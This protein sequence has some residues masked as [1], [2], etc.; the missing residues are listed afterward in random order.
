MEIGVRKK[1]SSSKGQL[2]LSILSSTT[3]LLLALVSIDATGRPGRSFTITDQRSLDVLWGS[4]EMK[5]CRDCCNGTP[6]ASAQGTLRKDR[7]TRWIIETSFGCATNPAGGGS[8]IVFVWEPSSTNTGYGPGWSYLVQA[9]EHRDGYELNVS[10]SRGLEYR[11][12]RRG[13]PLPSQLVRPAARPRNTGGYQSSDVGTQAVNAC[14]SRSRNH[15]R[16][17]RSNCNGYGGDGR[18]E[19]CYQ[20]CCDI[21][22]KYLNSPQY[23][24]CASSCTRAFLR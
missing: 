4:Y 5:Y 14:R 21:C 19:T 1:M 11:F 17:D 20:C 3:F 2:R 22:G 9:I 12:F 18:G 16:G 24:P 13:V 23:Q 15:L 8:G 7:Y 10:S 6:V